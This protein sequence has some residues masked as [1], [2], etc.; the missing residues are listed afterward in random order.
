MTYRALDNIF[1]GFLVYVREVINKIVF[2]FKLAGADMA[3]AGVEI[4]V[5]GSDMAVK[6]A[7][8]L[9][10]FAALGANDCFEPLLLFRR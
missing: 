2:G 8:L 3:N 5:G 7:L 6:G 9:E 10:T 1:G 4:A